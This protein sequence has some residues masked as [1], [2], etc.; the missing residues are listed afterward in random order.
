IM[1]FN[2][3]ITISVRALL[4]NRFRSF[5]TMLGVI[6]GVA[7]VIL[8]V[9]IGSG[10]QTF[11]TGE[12]QGLGSNLVTVVPGDIDF[13]RGGPVAGGGALGSFTTSKLKSED[14]ERIR[15]NVPGITEA[16]GIVFASSPIRYADEEQ[17]VQIAGTTPEFPAL[18]NAEIAYGEFFSNVD[19]A[20]SSRV[21]VLGSSVAENLFGN[22][23]EDG[24]G[25][26]VILGDLRYTVIGIFEK[27]GG[28]GQTSVDD[29]VM[30]PLSSV[31]QQFNLN[32]L[33][34]IYVQVADQETIP[35]VL[36]DIKI[37]LGKRLREDEFSVIDQAEILSAVSSILNTLTLAL[38]G[39]AAISLVVG[40]IGIMNI[41]LVSVAERTREIGLRKAV[42]ATPR[43]ILTQ[44]L[45]ESVILS[46]GGG[47]VGIAL[48][49][50]GSFVIGR[51]FTTTITW[52]AVL[53]AFGVSVFV[54][55]VFGVMPA[56]RAS[57]LSPIEALRY[58]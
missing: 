25:K 42:G 6:I 10:L 3:L 40:G 54:G 30:V 28:F 53:V 23:I 4:A 9:S 29:Q 32:N 13:G 15:E 11:V 58:E 48:G 19:V 50:G 35:R 56:R 46:V 22:T 24:V 8:L 21:I 55:I 49:I 27:S 14:V 7:S 17:N 36:S 1:P 52:W 31:Q 34:F 5:L 57:R 18:R 38:G 47:L 12:L 26:R 43:A 37:E 20:R 16:V 45:T 44:F 2:Q 33:S 41:M 51:F 39:I